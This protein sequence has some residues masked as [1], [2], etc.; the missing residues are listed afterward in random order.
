M[1]QPPRPYTSI[2][3]VI[4][5]LRYDSYYPYQALEVRAIFVYSGETV[6]IGGSSKV[7]TRNSIRLPL[8]LEVESSWK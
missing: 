5:D 1:R 3:S 7:P 6:E 2:V 4:G 8:S